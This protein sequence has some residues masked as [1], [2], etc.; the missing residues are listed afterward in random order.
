MDDLDGSFP[1][2]PPPNE[3]GPPPM[4]EEERQMALFWAKEETQVRNMFTLR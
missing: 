4:D 2:L 3:G 1:H